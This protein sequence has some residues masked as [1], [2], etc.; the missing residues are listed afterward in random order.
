M[1]PLQSLVSIFPGSCQ[2]SCLFHLLLLPPPGVRERALLTRVCSSPHRPRSDDDNPED[3]GD[4]GDELFTLASPARLSTFE[5]DES[6]SSSDE[7]ADAGREVGSYHEDSDD[8]EEEELVVATGRRGPERRPSTTE[9][10][11]RRPMWD[12]EEGEGHA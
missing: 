8:D 11:V 6:S 2:H 9:V 3:D 12:D 7:E 4:D 5:V 10:K 1:K